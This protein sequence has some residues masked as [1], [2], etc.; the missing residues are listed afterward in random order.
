MTLTH[1]A[2]T[3]ADEP[4][5]ARAPGRPRDPIVTERFYTAAITRI[6]LSGLQAVTVNQLALDIQAGKASFYRRWPHLD[7]FL[8]DLVRHLR[9]NSDS[10]VTA[11]AIVAAGGRILRDLVADDG[12]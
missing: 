11:D 7:Q 2:P 1:P 3:I 9:D 12:R 10:V 4:E 6:E 5:T 8:A